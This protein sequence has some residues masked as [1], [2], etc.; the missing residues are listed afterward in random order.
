MTAVASLVGAIAGS[1]GISLAIS[2]LA[3]RMFF[4]GIFDG[5]QP[6]ATSR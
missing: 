1:I 5:V 6:A 2:Y 4:M 3:I